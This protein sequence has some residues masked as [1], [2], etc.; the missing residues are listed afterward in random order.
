[1]YSKYHSKKCK[2][3][4]I[5]FHSKKEM[6]RYKELLLLQKANEINGLSL[7]VPFTLIEKSEYGRKIKYIADFV[8]YENGEVIVEDVK[9]MKTD[10]YKLKKRLF[11]E[12]YH[13]RIR[14][15]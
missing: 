9:G 14:E 5:V 2:Y 1:M 7:Q 13:I 3:N 10:V 12:K 6:N 4:D 8:Y 15:T 11:E